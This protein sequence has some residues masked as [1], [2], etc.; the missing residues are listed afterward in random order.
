MTN[1]KHIFFDLDHTLWDF[2]KN[3]SET[4]SELF[5]EFGLA[6]KIDNK[7]KFLATYQSV[8][9]IYWKKYRN[10]KI[11]KDT[12]RFGRF[13]D[14]LDRFNVKD[15]DVIGRQ[16][17]DEYVRRG[18]HKT[19]LFPHTH[20][21]LSYLKEKYPLHIITNGFKEVQFIK[22]SGSNLSQY[23][24][25]ILC[26]EEVGK[27]KPH[28]LVFEKALEMAKVDPFDALMIGDN[29][30][31]DILGAKKVGMQTIFFDPKNEGKHKHSKVINS[32]LEL[33]SLL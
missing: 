28:R 22:L 23:F 18:P 1:I 30:E 14:T 4:L 2:E 31:A 12:V 15:P 29:Y 33:K 27:Q 11:D 19:N 7:E 9:G 25:I 24:D 17:G 5:D 6:D 21:T 3:S 13:R 10:G 8:N 20:E 26:S 16:I 32:L